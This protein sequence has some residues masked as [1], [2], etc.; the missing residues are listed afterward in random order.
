[1][2]GAYSGNERLSLFV[3]C[4]STEPRLAWLHRGMRRCGAYGAAGSESR[5]NPGTVGPTVPQAG[6]VRRRFDQERERREPGAG[7]QRRSQTA[8]PRQLRSGPL[9]Q[10]DANCSHAFAVRNKHDRA[11]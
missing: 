10:F 1:M 6:A 9:V 2:R 4:S 8:V 11:A 7:C 5:P 3:P